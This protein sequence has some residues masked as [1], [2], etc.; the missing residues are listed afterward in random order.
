MELWK[1]LTSSPCWTNKE[2]NGSCMDTLL[3]EVM[4]ALSNKHQYQSGHREVKTATR[5]ICGKAIWKKKCGQQA[6]AQLEKD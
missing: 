5:K 3:Q 6:E 4:I 1:K 2:E